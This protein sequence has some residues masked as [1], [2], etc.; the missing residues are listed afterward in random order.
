MN[1]YGPVGSRRFGRSLGVDLVPHKTCCYDCLYCQVGA[2]TDLTVLRRTFIEPERVLEQIEQA[3]MG[4]NPPDVISLAGSGEPTLYQD[5]GALI[6]G[7]KER[8]N[9]PLVLITNGGLMADPA[10]REAAGLADILSP[11]LDAGD[12]ETFRKINRPHQGLNFQEMVEGLVKL[13]NESDAR[14]LL[15]ILLLKGINDSPASLKR[16]NVIA[17][18]IAPDRVHLNTA[19]RPVHHPG[20]LALKAGEMARA[21]DFFGPEAE[22]I[23][24][25][26]KSRT[27]DG[28]ADDSEIL[29]VLQRRPCTA[30]ELS[31]ALDF[32]PDMVIN[33][34]DRLVEAGKVEALSGTRGTYYRAT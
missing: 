32:H 2:T 28:R 17:R 3:L 27:T 20:A 9:L 34:I 13:R 8:F 22:I 16:L 19:V 1:I 14:Y 30:R 10:V 25:F 31:A 26:Q 7:I 5:L 4:R 29:R 15:E 23:A 12:E 21:L 33:I 24:S 11:S 18:R 6:R